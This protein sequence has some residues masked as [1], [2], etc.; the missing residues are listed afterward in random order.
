VQSGNIILDVARR[1]RT[2]NS[3]P[4]DRV[5]ADTSEAVG[6]LIRENRSLRLENVRLQR[7]V[8]RLSEGWAEIKRLARTAPRS[9]R[10]R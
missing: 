6:R 10:Q 4:L 1:R 3:S 5:L 9:R 7:E 8:T 2:D